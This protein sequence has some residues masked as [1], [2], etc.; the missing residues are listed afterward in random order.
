[1]RSSPPGTI[2]LPGL[3]VLSLGHPGQVESHLGQFLGPAR[4]TLETCEVHQDRAFGQELGKADLTFN[5][6]KKPLLPLPLRG[7]ALAPR[8]PSAWE[9]VLLSHPPP[10]TSFFFLFFLGCPAS[11]GAPQPGIRSE[12]QLQPK[13]LLQQLQILNS[14]CWIEPVSQGTQDATHP[15][16]PWR[17]LLHLP[18]MASPLFPLCLV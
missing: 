9:K 11:H 5:L 2:Q 1:M 17:E 16:A 3:R 10:F 14:L 12:Q 6:K 8:A 4:T 18:L 13:P 7:R 15:I